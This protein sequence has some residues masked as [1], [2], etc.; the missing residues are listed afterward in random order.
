MTTTIGRVGRSDTE[1]PARTPD[2][3]GVVERDGV[4]VHWE[5]YGSGPAILLLPAWSIVHSRQWKLSI[6]YLAR[7]FRVL[8]F[9]GRGN[10]RSD[11][12]S[13]GYAEQEFAADALAVMDAT[14][15]ETATLV[16]LSLGAQRALL[17]AGEHPERTTGAIFIC[18]AVP[19]GEPLTARLPH[20][21]EDELDSDVGW[22]KYNRHYWLRDYE[23]FLQF[24]FSQ[25]FNEP[26]STK[27]IEDAVGWGLDTTAETLV[28]T[29]LESG[30][31]RLEQLIRWSA[32]KAASLP[33]SD[34]WTA[35]SRD[36]L[37]AVSRLLVVRR[38]RANR[39]TAVAARRQLRQA[40]P[41][42]PRDAL[43]A[44]TGTA[45]WPGPALIWARASIQRCLG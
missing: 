18:P 29:E 28:A 7:H 15:T 9:D 26:H 44:L 36:A 12:P 31:R 43:E 39:E 40:Y 24:F 11:R 38:T 5:A 33:S 35:W 32:E 3:A 27:P 45:A 10:G 1:T 14:G 6:P 16:S 2:D 8:T 25:M 17:L 34:P 41:A 37:P 19:L 23:G 21:W 22:A 4:R 13:A 20:R 42:D 30:F